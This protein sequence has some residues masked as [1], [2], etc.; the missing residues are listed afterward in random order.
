MF[1]PALWEFVSAV[2]FRGLASFA[3]LHSTSNVL[4]KIGSYEPG[5]VWLLIK[6]Y[7]GNKEGHC[8]DYFRV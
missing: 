3:F 2:E 7:G 8:L 5:I 4:N 6:M 1:A